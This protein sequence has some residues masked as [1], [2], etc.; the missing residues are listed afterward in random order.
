MALEKSPPI[1]D[2]PSESA[3]KKAGAIIF[4]KANLRELALEGIRVSSLGEQ[5]ISP[6][7]LRGD[8]EVAQEIPMPT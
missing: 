3:F 8:Q 5:T 6:T 7:T 4:G 2:A 1:K